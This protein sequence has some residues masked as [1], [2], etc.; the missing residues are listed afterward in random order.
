MRSLLEDQARECCWLN[1]PA[2]WSLEDQVMKI[3]TQE[4]TDF[5]R[6]T[7]YGFERMNGHVFYKDIE[8]DFETEVHLT[9]EDPANRYD[10]SGLFIMLSEDCWLKVS[11]E[12]MPEGN[13]YLGSVI[14]NNGYSDWASKNFPAQDACEPLTFKVKRTSGTYQIWVKS[15]LSEGEYE[16]MRIGRLHED[17]H[18]K[19]IRIGLYACSPSPEASFTTTFHS[20]TVQL[21]VK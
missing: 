18:N 3:K 9:M 16:Q 8:G 20:W 10:Q 7:Y 21:E 11:L 12:Y 14:T 2:S 4:N 1:E 13:C 19:P 17:D 5:W 15:A 6:K